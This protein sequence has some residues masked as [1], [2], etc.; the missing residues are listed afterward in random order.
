MFSLVKHGITRLQ[1]T[2]RL[3]CY[4][5]WWPHGSS[6]NGTEPEWSERKAWTVKGLRVSMS[7]IEAIIFYFEEYDQE[8]DTT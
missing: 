7:K 5:A 3:R 1:E 2:Y 6:V 4:G 8:V